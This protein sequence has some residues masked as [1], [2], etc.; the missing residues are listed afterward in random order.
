MGGV[1]EQQIWSA[2]AIL[3]SLL[4]T[5]DSSLL[6]ESLQTLL[7]EIKAGLKLCPL[8]ADAMNNATSLVPR[9]NKPSHA[10]V[11]CCDAILK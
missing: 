1:W 6:D 8:T 5:H 7:F 2:R 11:K 4:R 3:N 10:E 9:S